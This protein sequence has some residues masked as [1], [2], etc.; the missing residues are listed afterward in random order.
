M[1]P[2]STRVIVS[3][4]FLAEA[5]ILFYCLFPFFHFMKGETPYLPYFY[6]MLMTTLIFLG[7]TFISKQVVSYM[8]LAPVIFLLGLLLNFS[9]LSSGVIAFVLVWRFIALYREAYL[10]HELFYIE[11]TTAVSL[12]YIIVFQAYPIAYYL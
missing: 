11:I 4:H 2:K 9:N 1:A 10:G 12:F 3:Y 5:V 7:M 6:L 8:L